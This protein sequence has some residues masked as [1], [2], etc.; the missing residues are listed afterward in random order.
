[1]KYKPFIMVFL[2]PLILIIACEDFVSF[3]D[4]NSDIYLPVIEAI[5]TDVPEVQ[6]V[7]VTWSVSVN[8]SSASRIIDNSLVKM[9]SSKG[10]TVL[11]DYV[12]DGWYHSPVFSAQAGITYSLEV[13][14]DAETYR[15]SGA[16][17]ELQDF[18]SVYYKY[19]RN[20]NNTDSS[21]YIYFDY[22]KPDPGNTKYYMVD[23]D[24]NSIRI[25]QGSRL[26][27]YE[28]RYLEYIKGIFVP[29]PLKLN[30][31]ATITAYSL[32]REMFDYYYKLGYHVFEMDLSSISYQTNLPQMFSP[33]ALG[34]FQV[35]SVRRRKIT[36]K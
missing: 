30:D 16:I 20:L 32:S 29:V 34:Y 5:L 26:F 1:M 21:Y 13:T 28:D 18:D 33:K 27:L 12:N 15:S 3:P 7:R 8:D 23:L 25:T 11:F 6:K 19:R 31:T 2:L 24:S 4:Q 9:I 22:A 14:I 35:S 10:D 36:I 17:Q